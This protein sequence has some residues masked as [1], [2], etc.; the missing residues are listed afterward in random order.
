MWV[1]RGG[2]CTSSM[3]PMSRGRTV[4]IGNLVFL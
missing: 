1:G 2:K 3:V 4:R